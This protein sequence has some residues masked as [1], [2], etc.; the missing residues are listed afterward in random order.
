MLNLS[1]W[2]MAGTCGTNWCLFWQFSS[3]FSA[4]WGKW[5]SEHLGKIWCALCMSQR[6]CG[7][8]LSWLSLRRKMGNRVDCKVH[9]FWKTSAEMNLL[10]DTCQPETVLPGSLPH[11]L[12]FGFR[13][14][15]MH[16]ALSWPLLL[17]TYYIYCPIT[18]N[19]DKGNHGFD[20]YKRCSCLCMDLCGFFSCRWVTT[21]RGPAQILPWLGYAG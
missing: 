5:G 12:T 3:H 6:T 18:A 14:I 9:I 15:V 2:L 11:A 10:E 7:H 17:K 20:K 13:G 1:S 16:L 19:N 4:A 8:G 21:L